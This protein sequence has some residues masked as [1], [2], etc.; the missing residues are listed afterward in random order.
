V[1]TAHDPNELLVS[2]EGYVKPGDKLD[3]TINYEN[4]GEGGMYG[5]GLDNLLFPR[6]EHEK[7]G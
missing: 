5:A 1:F 4:E 2:P 6:R 3:Y 7:N